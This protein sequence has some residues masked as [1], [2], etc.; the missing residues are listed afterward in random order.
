MADAMFDASNVGLGCG[1]ASGY[2]VVAPAGTDVAKLADTTKTLAEL[3]TSVTGVESLGYISEDGITI[4]FDIST[5]D[6]PHWANAIVK[7]PITEYKETLQAGFLEGR[8]SVLKAIF[9]SDNVTS[10]GGVVTVRHNAN[11]AEEK[12][13]VFDHIEGDDKVVRTIVPRATVSEI[14]D[15]QFSAGDPVTY[16]ATFN[17]LAYEGFDGDA[18]RDYRYTQTQAA[19]ATE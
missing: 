2:A 6:I 7:S 1:L 17:C 16:T 10:A 9:G 19:S 3:C 12:V 15:L 18:H 11:L 4:S 5:E 8:E 13:L 14:D